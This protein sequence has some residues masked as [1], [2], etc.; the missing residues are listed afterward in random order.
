MRNARSKLS[1]NQCMWPGP[2]T[3]SDLYDC[4]IFWRAVEVAMVMDLQKAYQAIHTGPMELHLRTLSCFA[5]RTNLCVG[6]LCLHQSYVRGCIG[7][8][9]P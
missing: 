9:N 7:W 6:R 1:L 5:S 4:L 8:S 2:N 3:L